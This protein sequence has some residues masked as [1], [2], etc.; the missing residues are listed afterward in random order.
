MNIS[1]NSDF[2]FENINDERELKST[3]P[4]KSENL[5]A[6]KTSQTHENKNVEISI[7]TKLRI[8]NKTIKCHVYNVKKHEKFMTWWKTIKWFYNDEKNSLNKDRKYAETSTKNRVIDNNIAK[9]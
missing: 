4:K 9:K 8:L 7:T 6:I 5:N 3:Q 1:F 2:L